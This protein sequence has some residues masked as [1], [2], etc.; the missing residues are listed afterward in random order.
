MKRM[1]RGAAF[2]IAAILCA[3][4][5]AWAPTGTAKEEA[6]KKEVKAKDAGAKAAKLEACPAEEVDMGM[7]LLKHP[8]MEKKALPG[9]VCPVKAGQVKDIGG[10]LERSRREECCMMPLRM[11]ELKSGDWEVRALAASHLSLTRDPRVIAPLMKLLESDPSEHVRGVAAGALGDMG[12]D[13]AIP[14]LRK[15]L[16]DKSLTVS[17]QAATALV[18]CGN[19]AAPK[20][21]LIF[22]ARGA[23]KRLAGMAQQDALSVRRAALG[24]LAM[25][26]DIDA[27][28][29]IR[30]VMYDE[31]EDDQVRC[32]AAEALSSTRTYNT[33]RDLKNGLGADA[34]GV[35]LCVAE[36]M[37]NKGDRATVAPTLLFIA[38]G[39]QNPSW[40]RVKALEILGDIGGDQV[41]DGV[42]P[43]MKDADRAVQSAAKEIVGKD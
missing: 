40:Q 21:F 19:A 20:L 18:E 7:R 38:K 11:R 17:M 26:N 16:D 33:S 6:S 27:Y 28:R 41:M 15:A 24:T 10:Y 4:I 22:V 23:T 5:L 12:S 1:V 25:M 3:A 31:R 9:T 14:T 29:T 37:K 35:A 32:Y 13:K 34:T 42:R 30:N 39:K 43:L 36:V 2:G 8:E